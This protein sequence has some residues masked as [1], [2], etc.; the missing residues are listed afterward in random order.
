MNNKIVKYHNDV[1]S[2]GL[3]DFKATE[4]D[5]FMAILSCM[6]DAGEGI[7]VLTFKEIKE[8]IHWKAKNNER[9]LLLL[10]STYDKLLN[11]IIRIGDSKNWTSFV[12]FTEYTVSGDNCEVRIAV[13]K[14][15]YY[16]L[17]ELASN[18]TRFELGEFVSLKSTYAKEFY[19]RM[20]QFRS[21]G[22]WRVSLEEFK[23]IMDIPEKYRIDAIDKFILAPIVAELGE[24]YR[25]EIKK[26]FTKGSRGRPSV[27]GFEFKFLKDSE[28]GGEIDVEPIALPDKAGS[29]QG[30]SKKVF[31]SEP[32]KKGWKPDME[33]NENLYLLR[34]IR[35]RDK[36]FTSQ[37]NLLKILDVSYNSEKGGLDVK[38]RNADDDY[39]NTMH[40][41]NV[42]T[43]DDYFNKYLV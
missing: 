15:F 37:Y 33:L 20:K 30:E 26:L 29:N 23:R 43:W 25:L 16:I 42:K 34:T 40:F 13:N 27:C 8:L 18:F 32:P 2:V 35:V 31:G 17:N 22:L 38:V 11:C 41:K 9:F 19:R 1:Y 14:R 3:R 24:K 39:V 12:L 5:I 7:V 4:L 28:R 6:R 21:T 10:Q 36:K